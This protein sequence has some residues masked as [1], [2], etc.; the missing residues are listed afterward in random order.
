MIN[1]PGQMSLFDL[2]ES[3]EQPQTSCAEEY[4]KEAIM[5][6]ENIRL[7]EACVLYGFSDPN[8][9][10]KLFKQ[11]FGYNITDKGNIA[12]SQIGCGK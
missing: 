10:S 6:Q 9:V 7:C 2:I 11:Y 12:D 4:L 1:V 8:Y 5:Q 3:Q